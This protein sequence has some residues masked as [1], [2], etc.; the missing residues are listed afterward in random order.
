MHFTQE[1]YRK[2]EDWLYQRTVKDTEFPSV[3]SLD[4]TE[5][6]PI[7]QDNKNK[8]IKLNSFVK[9]VADM[10]LPDFYNVTVNSKESFLTLRE[11]IS[12]VPVEQRKL[13]LTITYHNEY[14]NWLIYQF[15]GDSLNQWDSLNYWN[16]I[17]QQAIEEFVLYPDEED[18]TGVR[19]ENRTFL[20]FKNREYNPEEFSGMGMI[21]LRKNLVGTAAC[22][23][24]DEDHLNNILT[25]DMINQENTVYIVQYDFDLDGKV[26]SIPKGCTLWFQGGSINNGTI[27]LQET[28]ILGAFE[29]ADMGNAKLFG[30]FNTG[31]VMTFS[32]DS[33]K[34]KTGGYFVAGT[35]SSSAT[36]E[37]DAKNE[38][39]VFYDKNPN[40]YTTETRQ[41]L[42]W[43][44]GEE[45]IL[46]LDITDY[47]EIKSIINDLIEKHNAEMAACYKYFK[48]RCY[49]L[50][51]RMDNA[52]DTLKEHEKQLNT[53]EIRLNEHDTIL[54]E[55]SSTLNNHETRIT[56]NEGDI[57]SI[58]KEI[59]SINSEITD[60]KEDITNINSSISN[61]EG[62]INNITSNISNIQNTVKNLGD[63]VNNLDQ[64]IENHIQQFIE[65]NVVG[66]ASITVN[67]T[68]YNPDSNGNITLPN[69][70]EAGGG[71]ADK[72]KGTLKFTGAVSASYNGSTD[73]T[74]NIP[75]G[76]S[77][78]GGGVADSVKGTL[79]VKSAEGTTLGTYNGS[80]DK[81]I[82]LPA[83]GGEGGNTYNTA[84]EPLTLKQGNTTLG[85]YTGEDPVTISIPEFPEYDKDGGTADKV[86]HKLKFTGAV[87]AEYDGSEE[88]SV[89]IPVGGG[90]GEGSSTPNQPL[91]FTGAV[92]ETYD[93]TSQK[94]VNIPVY[95]PTPATTLEDLDTKSLVIKNSSGT[96]VVSYNA[97]ADKEVQFNKLHIK[98]NPWD[99]GTLTTGAHLVSQDI[100]LLAKE[101]TID[102]SEARFG[103]MYTG[104]VLTSGTVSRSSSTSN[105]WFYTSSRKH[106]FLAVTVQA[107]GAGVLIKLSATSG[108]VAVTSAV[109]SYESS[110]N[111]G[112]TSTESS[113]Y[114]SDVVGVR[115]G[116][117]GNTVYVQGIRTDDKNNDSINTDPA[118]SGGKLLGFNM[119]IIGYISA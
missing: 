29:F 13:G 49:A 91:I 77:S 26:I 3:D 62:D 118:A 35:K 38:K 98:N 101:G 51:V 78:S 107:T 9:Q 4:G 70:P 84:K 14:G 103:S 23:I 95:E 39:E 5:M 67:G 72:T 18:I 32:D 109:C 47:N 65:D 31:Q 24:D 46:I 83:S 44:N 59:D 41:E 10:K 61:I 19:D 2:I 99:A 113:R 6:V 16:S 111:S 21:I 27:Y 106:P 89:N 110:V 37:E 85:T 115:S 58:N 71:T 116:I 64:T 45:W 66:V 112:T 69:Y 60:V 63:V 114:R 11:A 33:Y 104:I 12:L 54:D 36:V 108:S 34:A 100:D 96:E 55:H 50:E 119:I 93:G 42:R 80:T 40:A 48:A 53:H 68:K 102:L 94:T 88:V 117:N 75:E 17:I 82:T 81:T 8:T 76:G 90:S 28:A 30:K 43:W 74:V 15:K 52:E 87:T 79:T 22:S 92:T 57:T 1:D 56:K 105:Y 86:A 7:L 25:Q 20:K 97:K 73:V